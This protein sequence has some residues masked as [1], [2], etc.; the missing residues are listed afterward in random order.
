MR[1]FLCQEQQTIYST[2]HEKQLS[3]CL[4][5]ETLEVYIEKS[6]WYPDFRNRRQIRNK[7][8]LNEDGVACDYKNATLT[9]SL[10]LAEEMGKPTSPIVR[11]YICK[12][13]YSWID[14]TN[15][16][17]TNCLRDLA[18]L[19]IGIGKALFGMVMEGANTLLKEEPKPENMF[20]PTSNKNKRFGDSEMVMEGTNTFLKEEPKPENMFSLTSNKNK[21]F[22]DS[23]MVMEGTNTFLKEEPKPEN[24]FSLTSNKNKRAN[25][26]FCSTQK[27]CHDNKERSELL[28]N[29]KF[30]EVEIQGFKGD[31]EKGK[32]KFEA[33]KAMYYLEHD[34]NYLYFQ[35]ATQ[36]VN[37]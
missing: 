26:L 25:Q 18:Y 14:Y 36:Y 3:L 28:E 15:I 31:W 30:N 11:D 21:R 27:V 16:N 35:Q 17:I 1:K 7:G 5:L 10:I 9:Q 33:I 12:E 34:N 8:L 29:K 19:L 6:N 37:Q 20:S 32:E 24:M 2:V 13:F 4:T 23:E 22:G